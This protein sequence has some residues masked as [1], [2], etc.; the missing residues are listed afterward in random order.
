MFIKGFTYGFDGRRGA[1]QT[2]EAL[3]SMKK[4]SETGCEW[5]ALAFTIMQDTYSSTQIRP[6]Y[7]Y[8][9]TDKDII[10]AV[11]RFHKLGV[12][13]CMK[14]IV[15][16]ADGVW[17]AHISFPESDF[18]NRIDYWKEWFSSYTAFLCHYAEIAEETGCEMFCVGC[19]ML[20]TEQKEEYWRRTIE[21]VRQV[22]HG[23]LVY[24]T[25]HG[26][27]MNVKWWD[28]LDYIGTSAY[29]KVAKCPGDSLENMTSEWK[30]HC[31]NLEKVSAENGGKQIIFMEIGCR[32]AKGCAMMPYDFNHKEFPYDEDEQANFY[33]SCIQ[34]F[35]DKKWFGGF[36]WWDWY[37]KL[38][39]ASHE[40][41]FSIFG[42]KAE[43]VIRDWY[44]R[45]RF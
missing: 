21:C 4:L 27:E 41:G 34:T 31:D 11:E 24:N 15:N 45:E 39:A 28:A 20:G 40:T 29:Y 37:T 35:W 43:K 36:F 42:K 23:P 12:K 33:E 2:E 10:T 13:V 9:V 1:Y 3:E 5:T 7:R 16:C 19:E 22:Y 25:N 44:S 14:P 30:K 17:R 8:T 32:S 18:A 38:P 6:D 26:S